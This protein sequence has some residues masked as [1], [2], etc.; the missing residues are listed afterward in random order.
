MKEIL[1]WQNDRW[2]RNSQIGTLLYD[3]HYFFGW[4]VFESLRTYN[5]KVFLIDDHIDRLYRSTQLA[6]I[7]F[8]LS[9]KKLERAIYHVLDKNTR[10]FKNDEYRIMVFVS[11]GLFR[12]YED[13]GDIEPKVTINVTTASRYAPHIYPF[14]K[15]GFTGLI[16][17]QRQIPNRFLD[18]RI[19]SCSRLHYGIAEAEA[20]RY[21]KG[22]LPILL[23][24]HDYLTETTGANIAFLKDGKLHLPY[25]KNVLHG[26]TMNFLCEFIWKGEIVYGDWGVYDLLDCEGIVFASTFLGVVPCYEIILRNEHHKLENIDMSNMNALID[27]FSQA[28]DV[29]IKKQWRE[30]YEKERDTNN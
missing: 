27:G 9:K 23:D 14:L 8:D 18:S 19:K 22:V 20:A 25:W 13:I 26:C 7:K 21:G 29:D 12:I 15:K 2:I 6:E 30:W 28:V 1:S 10:F 24:E 4:A 3:A 16:S 11:P 17:S 5:H